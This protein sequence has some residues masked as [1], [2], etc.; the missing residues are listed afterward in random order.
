[1]SPK[2]AAAAAEL[3][4]AAATG[5]VRQRRPTPSFLSLTMLSLPF[6]ILFPDIPLH[7]FSPEPRTGLSLCDWL[8]T[9]SAAFFQNATV[10]IAS[11][12]STNNTWARTTATQ[13]SNF[14]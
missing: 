3:A 1:M 9:S 11:S 4:V 10:P 14:A 13:I 6:P 12:T 7:L 8:L 5:T 2:T